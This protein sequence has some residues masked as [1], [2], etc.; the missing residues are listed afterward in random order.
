MNVFSSDEN[1]RVHEVL[2][3]LGG[4]PSLCSLLGAA[5]ACPPHQ[6]DASLATMGQTEVCLTL[7]NKF[8]ATDDHT[9]MDKLFVK[10]KQVIFIFSPP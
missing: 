8:E 6:R 9:D 5:E 3:A 4:K 7:T 1:D 10:T 2:D